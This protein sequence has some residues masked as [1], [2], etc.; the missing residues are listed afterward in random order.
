M[1]PPV[2]T[3]FLAWFYLGLT[4]VCHG[5]IIVRSVSNTPESLTRETPAPHLWSPGL[6]MAWTHLERIQANEGLVSALR[7]V[8][9]EQLASQ[10]QIDQALAVAGSMEGLHRH[11]A[12]ARLALRAARSER[13]D[14]ARQLYMEA[15]Q[16]LAFADLAGCQQI[17]AELAGAAAALDMT[18]EVA[19]MLEQTTDP[20]H[21][22]TALGNALAASDRRPDV[23]PRT[24]ALLDELASEAQ[25]K[26][27]V[28]RIY[29]ARA[30][31]HVAKNWK[32]SRAGFDD[33]AFASL[34]ERSVRF[35]ENKLLYTGGHLLEAASALHEAALDGHAE[36]V[37]TKAR[38]QTASGGGFERGPADMIELARVWRQVTGADISAE[39]RGKCWELMQTFDPL[40]KAEAAAMAG[41]AFWRLGDFSSAFEAWLL[42]ATTVSENAN[43]EWTHETLVRIAIEAAR[44]GADRDESWMQ[45]VT[46]LESNAG[47]A[48]KEEA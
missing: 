34:C 24:A 8:I 4:G 10:G 15:R 37:L 40:M 19:L 42:A 32:Q 18:D 1:R 35:A 45:Q 36:T 17:Q 26:F 5:Q 7:A 43:A 20:E 44:C 48:G 29:Q 33:D 38:V 12:D 25:E 41:S 2:R 6:R 11:L 47:V 9:S 27:F 3:V 16:G 39:M 28:T 22:A 13:Q 46:E 21:L 30:V 23:C 31:L 14:L